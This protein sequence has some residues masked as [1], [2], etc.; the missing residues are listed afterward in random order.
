MPIE[1]I[2][3]EDMDGNKLEDEPLLGGHFAFYDAEGYPYVWEGGGTSY[4]RVYDEVTKTKQVLKCSLVTPMSDRSKGVYRTN[5][6]LKQFYK[7]KS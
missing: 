1:Y 4:N 5:K 2:A 7:T 3:I 6:I